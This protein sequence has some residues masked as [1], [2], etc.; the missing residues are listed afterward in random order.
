MVWKHPAEWGWKVVKYRY[1]KGL[2][3]AIEITAAFC[4]ESVAYW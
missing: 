2:K 4:C 3:S 1:L